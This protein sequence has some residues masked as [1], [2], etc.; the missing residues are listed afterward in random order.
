[1]GGP[2][3]SPGR[4][5]LDDRKVLSGILFVLITEA[6]G[7]PLVQAVSPV[8]GRRGRPRRR[9]ACNTIRRRRLKNLTLC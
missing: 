9:L 4:R 1:M 7:I 5:R 3:A 6:R 2:S 8:R